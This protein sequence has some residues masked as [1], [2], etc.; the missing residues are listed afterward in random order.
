MTDYVKIDNTF[1][2]GR[3]IIVTKTCP[4]SSSQ[5]GKSEDESQANLEHT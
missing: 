2:N 5:V 3:I 1:P 4:Y